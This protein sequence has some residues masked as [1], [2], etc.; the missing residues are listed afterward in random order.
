MGISTIEDF[1]A[2]AA[3]FDLYIDRDNDGQIIIYT[4]F[5]EEC[6]KLV[7]V[8]DDEDPDGACK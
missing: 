3:A 6:G 1:I 2:L 7:P 8:D 4:G 5:K